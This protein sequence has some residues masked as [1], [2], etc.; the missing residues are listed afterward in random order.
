[1]DNLAEAIDMTVAFLGLRNFRLDDIT[2]KTGFARNKAIVDAKEAVNENDETRKRFEI[3]AR[4]VFKKF[5]AK[6]L[7]IVKTKIRVF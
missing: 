5:K 2:E 3:M 4:E 7:P 6:V 1:L